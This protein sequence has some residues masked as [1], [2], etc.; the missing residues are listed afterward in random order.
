MKSH[1]EEREV[2]TCPRPNC[3]RTYLEQKNLTAHIKSYHEGHRFSCQYEGCDR[4]FST[5][6]KCQK[7]TLLHQMKG[8]LPKKKSRKGVKKKS[9]AASV[10]GIDPKLIK[11]ESIEDRICL[12]ESESAHEEEQKQTGH[13]TGS[14]QYLT[15]SHLCISNAGVHE[16]Q[17]PGR[18]TVNLKISKNNE[19]LLLNESIIN[20][21]IL[22]RH[23]EDELIEKGVEINN[24]NTNCSKQ[25]DANAEKVYNI[26][27]IAS[28]DHAELFGDSQ[29]SSGLCIGGNCSNNTDDSHYDL[30]QRSVCS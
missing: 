12:S 18:K 22:N 7:H 29:M 3:G 24:K 1:C 19:G 15:E 5:K 4:N 6:Q 8:T 9:C 27:V 30:Y 2:Y 13:V 11:C 20:I 25:V 21:D 17:L 16:K 23:T 28:S 26:P 14:V 10:T